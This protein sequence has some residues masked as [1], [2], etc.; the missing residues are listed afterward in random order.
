MGDKVINLDNIE[1]IVREDD[2]VVRI[3]FIH[4]D[5]ALWNEQGAV[6]YTHLTLPTKR[7]V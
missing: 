2:G 3:H 5:I 4:V 7:I 6:S 1:Y